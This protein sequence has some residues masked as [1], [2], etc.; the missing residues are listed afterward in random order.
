[1]A[2]SVELLLDGGLDATVREQWHALAR[3]GVPSLAGHRSPSNRPHVTLVASTGPW[4]DDVEAALAEA[5]G[6]LPVPIRLSGLVIFTN[7]ARLVLARLVVPTS[8]LLALQARL[9]VALGDLPGIVPHTRPGSWAP[10]VTLARTLQAAELPVALTAL[11]A[12]R[13]SSDHVGT[14]VA[15]RRWDGTARRDWLLK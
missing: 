1:M 6:P 4:P 5:V 11:T 3:A 9:A 15:V 12:A 14:G 7:G 10:H 8:G 2:Q 13:A